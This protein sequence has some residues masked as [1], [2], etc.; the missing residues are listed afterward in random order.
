M[1][2]FDIM[3][4][5]ITFILL[6]ITILLASCS[7]ASISL[8]PTVTPAPVSTSTQ[9]PTPT[10]PPTLTPLPF[11]DEQQTAQTELYEPIKL[12]D[13]DQ[14]AYEQALSDIPLYRQGEIE[15]TLKDENGKTLSGYMIKYR[16]TSHDF[17]FGGNID[18]FYISELKK[19][20]INTNTAFM[21]WKW[22]QPEE[23]EYQLDFTN[24]WLGLD[25]LKSGGVKLKTNNLFNFGGDN[26]APYLKKRSYDDFIK[27]VYTHVSTVVKRFAPDVDYWEAVLEPDAVK[28]NPLRLTKDEYYQA[29][30]TSVKAIRENDPTATIEINLGIPCGGLDWL[31][32]YQTTQELL[33]RNIDFDVVGLQFYYNAYIAAGNYPMPKMSFA[34]MS[35][36]YDQYA[37]LLVP[38]G[39]RVIGSEF[40]VPSEAPAG[41]SGY[42]TTAW[43]EDSQAQYLTTAYTIFFSKPSNLGLIWWNTVEP[44]PYVYRGALIQKDGTPKKSFYALQQLVKNW[45]TTGEGVTDVNGAIIF[46]GFGGGYEIE[47]IDPVNRASMVT[48]VHVTEQKSTSAAIKF[49]PNNVL[50]EKQ[51]K[52]E[53]LI[54]YWEEQSNPD[55]VRKGKEYLALINHHVQNSEWS[56]A[57]QTINVALDELAIQ[58]EMDI[59]ASKLIPVG[60]NGNGFTMEND[61]A[62]IWGATT[63][64]FP[65]NFPD[66]TV[67]VEIKAHSKNEKGE[68]PLMVSGIGANYSQVWKVENEQTQTYRFIVSTNGTEQYLTIRFPYDDR[69]YERITAQKGDAGELKLYIDQVS[70]IIKTTEIH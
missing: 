16:Q 21:Y 49:I 19:A 28:N 24:Y 62:L 25:E 6:L 63:L 50:L 27:G 69:I 29:I 1:K 31:N 52:L 51:T 14:A 13:A 58:I 56:L 60:S 55:L 30:A 17:I 59:P 57:S 18:P 41:Q 20:G 36:C 10:L 32:S 43:S 39:K 38:H 67:T 70:L 4:K 3:M 44:S 42:W 53:K 23:G 64:H 8:S 46:K 45:T 2:G 33:N 34:K 61:S 26:L 15:L 37:E 9:I 47:I 22:I 7:P 5:R 54:T 68:S 66:G 11:P 48:Q 40:S 12:S 65:Y 35:A